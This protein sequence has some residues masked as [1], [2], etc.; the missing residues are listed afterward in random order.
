MICLGNHQEPLAEKEEKGTGDREGNRGEGDSWKGL[1]H[2]LKG[3]DG[4]LAGNVLELV[5]AVFGVKAPLKGHAQVKELEH[6][7]L[8]DGR[9]SSAEPRA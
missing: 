6:N 7:V 1:P 9:P 2:L 5:Q 8:V 3:A 4:S